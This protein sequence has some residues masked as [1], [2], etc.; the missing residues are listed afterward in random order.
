MRRVKFRINHYHPCFGSSRNFATRA[1]PATSRLNKCR[2][3][4]LSIYTSK[5]YFKILLKLHEPLGECN[6]NHYGSVSQRLGTTK[7]AVRCKLKCKILD[8]FRLTMFICESAKKPDEK[9]EGKEEN[10]HW[11]N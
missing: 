8:Y 1:I 7:F 11:Q 6:L 3:V 2:R 5:W 10:K 9:T 4:Q